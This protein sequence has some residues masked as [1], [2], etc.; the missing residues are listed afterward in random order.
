MQSFWNWLIQF[1][2]LSIAPNVITLVGF[3]GM[4]GSTVLAVSEAPTFR[5]PISLAT[6]VTVVTLVFLYQTLDALDGKQARRTKN[7]TPLGQLFDHGC[8]AVSMCCFAMLGG[9]VVRQGVNNPFFL[10]FFF[11]SLIAFYLAQWEEYWTGVIDLG[12]IGVT[13]G[14]ILGMLLY[15][16]A[17]VSGSDQFLKV[18]TTVGGRP[19]TLGEAVLSVFAAAFIG[20]TFQNVYRVYQATKHQARD[21]IK[22]VLQVFLILFFFSLSHAVDY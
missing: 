11:S 13:E 17:G 4:I 16:W 14:Q 18:V 6:I 8:D 12:E 19:I 10:T 9:V 22:A 2:P 5:E 1:M 3:V 21:Q 7:S 20:T 15:V